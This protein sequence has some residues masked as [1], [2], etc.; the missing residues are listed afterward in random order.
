MQATA[1]MLAKQQ[2]PFLLTHGLLLF[3]AIPLLKCA[4]S[5][6][7]LIFWGVGTIFDHF[8]KHLYSLCKIFYKLFWDDV[9]IQEDIILDLYF[10]SE[11]LFPMPFLCVW[12]CLCVY[13]L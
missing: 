8:C 5:K 10:G 1:L 6:W 4:I 13:S 9:I 2:I 3:F 11:D 12:V 7:P